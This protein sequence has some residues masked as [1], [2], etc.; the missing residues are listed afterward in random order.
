MAQPEIHVDPD[1]LCA[2]ADLLE[3]FSRDI[4]N[5]LTELTRGLAS[6]SATWQDEEY[7][8]FKNALQPMRRKLDEFREEIRKSRPKLEADAAAIRDYLRQ[9]AP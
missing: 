7:G 6:L 4:D 2:I 1:R 3:T 8:K 9:E 5:Q